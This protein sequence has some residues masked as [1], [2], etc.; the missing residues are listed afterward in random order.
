M[1]KYVVYNIVLKELPLLFP[2]PN[3][4]H[5]L[6]RWMLN[7]HPQSTISMDSRVGSYIVIS[8]LN[9]FSYGK[10]TLFYWAR[11]R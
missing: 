11:H 2:S 9:H 5:Y 6:T 3:S 1:A 10:L 7:N 8:Q 4:E